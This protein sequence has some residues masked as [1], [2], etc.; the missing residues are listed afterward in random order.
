M[1]AG[2]HFKTRD[3]AAAGADLPCPAGTRFT[4]PGAS[5]A[6]PLSAG[7]AHSAAA[8]SRADLPAGTRFA[9]PCPDVPVSPIETPAASPSRAFAPRPDQPT[10]IFAP[11]V[12]EPADPGRFASE[13]PAP[14]APSP[15]T[16]GAFAVSPALA[17][18]PPSGIS[19]DYA[20]A[21]EFK[22]PVARRVL[23][24]LAN[25]L[26]TLIFIAA[27]LF[28]V[29]VVATTLTSRGGEASLFGWKPYVVLSDSMQQ[30]FQVGD[31]VVTREVDDAASLQP[32]DIISFESIDP[33]AYGEV[34]THRIREAT[35]YEGEQAF[36]TYGSTTGDD[37]AYPALA[38]RVLGKLEFVIPK[39]GYAFDFFKSPAGYVVLVLIPFSILIG[40]QV[41]NIVRLVREDR[42]E[43]ARA[44]LAEQRRVAEMEAE[45]ERLR[46]RD[47][48]GRPRPPLPED[49]WR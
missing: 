28:T 48:D 16:T 29:M 12:P 40:L 17:A 27:L 3:D 14:A 26:S 23:S 35:E 7:A 32:G 46:R 45:I 4:S 10:D 13:A 31:I 39:A 21:D 2:R 25:V 20:N 49:A 38:S 24:V 36:V 22:L 42:A 34:F 8:P 43:Q 9:A 5:S 44:L 6:S 19:A 47:A 30:D 41:R 33:D 1:A 37:D 11:L 15:E 18:T